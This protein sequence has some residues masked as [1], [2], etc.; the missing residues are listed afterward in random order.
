[1]TPD[2]HRI[3]HEGH[4]VIVIDD[5]FPDVAALR[6]DAASK[7]FQPMGPHYPGI[8]AEVAPHLVAA[9]MADLQPVMRETFGLSGKIDV[10]E[11]L[12]SLVTTPQVRLTPIQR[13]PH[14]DGL[15]SGR[16]ALLHYLSP[17]IQ[18]GTAFYRHR[19]TGYEHVDRE[20]YP[21]YAAKLQADVHREGLP[22]AAYIAGDTPL[23]EQVARFEARPN[24]ALIY[25]G[26][27]LHCADL[28]K[29][30]FPADV[31]TGR[32]TVNTF[33]MG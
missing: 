26:F 27:L 30:D 16:L 29:V 28:P 4:P 17:A 14:F 1:M 10:V 8:R 19:T 12:Y 2:I 6:A 23:F 33:L 21:A 24:R 18:G 22:A 3:G 11:S 9:F 20:R 5:F 7:P 15:E 13:M 25:Q 32:L 31:A